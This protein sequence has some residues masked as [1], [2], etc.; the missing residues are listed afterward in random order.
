M[1][2]GPRSPKLP[3]GSPSGSGG[4]ADRPA[5]RGD[6]NGDGRR[7]V[8]DAIALLECLFL[9]HACPAESCGIDVNSDAKG[10]V[11]DAISL[12]G[13]LFLRGAAPDPCP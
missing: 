12:L 9:G 3:V 4:S 7:D 5:L 1:S 10:D 11:S 13:F 2:S 6:A 8:S